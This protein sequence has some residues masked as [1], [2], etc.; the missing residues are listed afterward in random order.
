MLEPHLE[1]VE[2]MLMEFP[3]V[4]RQGREVTDQKLAVEVEDK[5]MK[6]NIPVDI[7]YTEIQTGVDQYM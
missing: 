6:E 3:G 1:N 7:H 4:V 2:M 5:D